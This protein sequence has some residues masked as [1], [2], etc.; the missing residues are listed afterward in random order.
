MAEKY[1]ILE[2]KN[3]GRDSVVAIPSRLDHPRIGQIFDRVGSMDG[4]S[5]KDFKEGHLNL[6]LPIHIVGRLAE[7]SLGACEAVRKSLEAVCKSQGVQFD[8]D[9]MLRDPAIMSGILD[10]EIIDGDI[11]VVRFSGKELRRPDEEV[12]RSIALLVSKDDGVIFLDGKNLSLGG[13]PLEFPGKEVEYLANSGSVRGSLEAFKSG[14]AKL[15]RKVLKPYDSWSPS[16]N[17]HSN[18]PWIIYRD[19]LT[20]EWTEGQTELMSE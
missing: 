16:G 1:T 13:K 12:I 15:H 3:L 11:Y 2:E 4:I 5:E 14:S 19:N 6:H 8:Q 9:R 18:G 7:P 20:R 10:Y 17:R